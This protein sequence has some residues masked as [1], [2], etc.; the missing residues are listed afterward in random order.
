MRLGLCAVVAAA[1]AAAC[2]DPPPPPPFQIFVK[3]E[4]DPGKPIVGATVARQRT[5]GPADAAPPSV[6][7]GL[8]G[9]ALLSMR[10]VDGEIADVTVQCPD[11]Y[12]SPS[13]PI[14]VR[15]QRLAEK[16]I[17]EYS[18]SCPPAMRKVVV[19]VRA[20]NGPDL[21]VLYLGKTITRTD[22]S[23]AAHFAL[24]VPPGAQFA[25]GLDTSARKDL[26]PQS[27][28]KPFNVGQ[29]D[30]VLVFDQPF[31]V[32]KKRVIVVGPSIPRAIGPKEIP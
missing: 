25:V 21:P 5:G 1:A 28:Q 27:P 3:V 16:K 31:Q 30:D 8:D 19:A 6:T 17:P 32:E 12:T 26:K 13:K 22:A 7:T 9:R 20:E 18:V 11:G 14:S 10:G 15:L 2:Q 24:E 4:S 23:G 29:N